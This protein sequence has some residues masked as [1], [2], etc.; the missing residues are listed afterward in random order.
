MSFAAQTKKELTLIMDQ[1]CCQKSELEAMIALNGIIQALDGRRTLDVETENVATA[2]RIY[3]LM[4][5]QF[6]IHPEVLVR[7]K[8]RLKKNNV[9]AVRVSAQLDPVLKGAGWSHA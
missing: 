9:Y 4:K 3:T 2:R 8:M 1:D 5:E 6:T 7:K